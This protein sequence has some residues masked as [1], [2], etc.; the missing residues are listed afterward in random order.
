MITVFPMGED[1]VHNAREH[2]P[3]VLNDFLVMIDL[4]RAWHCSIFVLPTAT[5]EPEADG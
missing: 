5:I 3:H 2:D 1:L 4:P